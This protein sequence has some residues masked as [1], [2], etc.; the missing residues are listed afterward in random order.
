M[1]GRK[2][3]LNPLAVR[4]QLLIAESEVNRVRLNQEWQT[5]AKE[6]GSVAERA[7]SFGKM[8]ASA[9]LLLAGLV[10]LRRNAS[11]PVAAKTSWLGKIIGGVRMAT[12]VWLAW[13]THRTESE[14]K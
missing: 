11:A 4:K 13:R 5:L 6:I 3:R 10:A 2:P 7:Q 8:A 14:K 12:T 1:F 9:T